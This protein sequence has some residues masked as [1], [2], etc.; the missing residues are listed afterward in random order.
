MR[1]VDNVQEANED[2]SNVKG[3][4]AVS[5]PP[6]EIGSSACKVPFRQLI[7]T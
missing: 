6:A 5:F 3:S 2:N 4:G 7:A 1:K